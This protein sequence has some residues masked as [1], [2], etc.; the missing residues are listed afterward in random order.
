[1][2][3]REELVGAKPARSRQGI[4][5]AIGVVFRM[6]RA[7]LGPLWKPRRVQF[8]HAAPQNLSVHRRIFGPNLSFGGEFN[9][10]VCDA[11]DLD[12]PNPSADPAMASHAERYVDSLPGARAPGVAQDV[13]RAIVE[14]LPRGRASIEQVAQALGTHPRALQRMLGDGESFSGLLNDARRELA[15]RY[16]ENPAYSLTQVAELLGYGFP[17]SFS[18]WFAAEFGS[19][20]RR[21]RS[22]RSAAGARAPGG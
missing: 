22:E 15:L 19:S 6:F 4:E 17:S 9:G 1:V 10:I 11:A 7:L 18:R 20:P 21:W 3:V 13:R 5:L 2:V 12:R 16:L 8:T 14:L